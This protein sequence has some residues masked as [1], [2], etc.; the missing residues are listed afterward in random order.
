MALGWLCQNQVLEAVPRHGIIK[1]D[2][3][4]LIPLVSNIFLSVSNRWKFRDVR[5]L[6][7]ARITVLFLCTFRLI[8]WKKRK[9]MSTLVYK[10]K[11]DSGSLSK[12]FIISFSETK[13]IGS[14]IH[15]V[16]R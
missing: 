16:T 11:L 4:V 8:T 3:H 15:L 1:P 13:R 9:L 10:K 7:I 5:E 2:L 14:K 12:L 6:S